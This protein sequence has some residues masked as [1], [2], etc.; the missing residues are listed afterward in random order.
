MTSNTLRMGNGLT[1]RKL[2]GIITEALDLIEFRLTP[3]L[4]VLLNA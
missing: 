4:P 3:T 2:R 1:M